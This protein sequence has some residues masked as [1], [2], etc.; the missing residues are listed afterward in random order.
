MTVPSTPQI[1]PPPARR[2]PGIAVRLLLAQTIVLV[3]GAA[4]AAIVAAIV[5]PPL[6]RE[7]LHRAGVPHASTEQFHA[8]EAYTYAT[9]ISV[10]FALAVALIIA[11][12]VTWY[13][14]RRLH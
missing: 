13:F 8:E 9:A 7:H 10:G 5:G 1:E 6:F 4:T 14:S 3:A 12:I 11:L 2:V